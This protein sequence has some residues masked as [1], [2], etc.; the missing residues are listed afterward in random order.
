METPVL[1]AIIGA[2]VSLGGIWLN[3][4]L[5]IRREFLFRGLP[6]QQDT[7]R[8]TIRRDWYRA[9]LAIVTCPVLDILVFSLIYS[10]LWGESWGTVMVFGII[11][12][13][14]WFYATCIII[15]LPVLLFFYRRVTLNRARLI[16]AVA[17]WSALTALYV[18]FYFFVRK[19]LS[20]ESAGVGLIS[21]C[22]SGLVYW[23]ITYRSFSRPNADQI[24]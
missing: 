6:A 1:V 15:M 4:Y 17:S 22:I 11:D 12:A 7:S 16:F 10:Q 5:A 18:F 3:H 19:E 2:F 8:K 13:A 23:L 21:G 24:I 9:V 14:P 20:F